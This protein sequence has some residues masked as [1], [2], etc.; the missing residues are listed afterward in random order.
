MSKINPH[1]ICTWDPEAD[2]EKCENRGRLSCKW[3][4]QGLAGFLLPAFAFGLVAVFGIVMVGIIAGLWWP[5]AAYLGFWVFFFTFF[6]IRIL[7]SHC[8]YY[9]RSGRMLHCLANHGTIKLWRYHP[10]PMNRFE[11]ISLI[12]G[13]IIFGAFPVAVQAYGIFHMASAYSTYGNLALLGMIGITGATVLCIAAFYTVLW[14][15]FCPRCVNFSCPFN[16][17]PKK[18]VD[19]YLRRNPVMWKAWKKA[20]YKLG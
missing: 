8:P 9:A 19:S 17:V 16:R 18:Q 10:E 6:E 11:K 2:C 7:C 13:F 4:A 12:V 3:S 5:L 14:T 15:L 20:G 1:N